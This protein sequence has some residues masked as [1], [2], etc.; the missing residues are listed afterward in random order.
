MSRWIITTGVVLV[1]IGITLHF[2]PWVITWF[3]HLPGDIHIKTGRS[4]IFIP[5]T[6]MIIV[7]I[8]LTLLFNLFR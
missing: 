8:L 2:A 1:V 3:G 7:S 6:S 5:V 4:E